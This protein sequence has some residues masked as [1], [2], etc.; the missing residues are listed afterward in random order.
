MLVF[1]NVLHFPEKICK[2]KNCKTFFKNKIKQNAIS[3]ELCTIQEGSINISS[4]QIRGR[5]RRKY[6]QKPGGGAP[7]RRGS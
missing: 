3:S 1:E 2:I 4:R 5:S 7:K 6:I